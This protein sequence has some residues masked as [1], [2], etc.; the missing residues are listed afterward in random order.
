[1]EQT[2]HG[3]LLF[4][5]T[6]WALKA[7][8]AAK[9]ASIEVKLIPTPR[10]LSSDCGTALRFRW[11]DRDALIQALSEREVTFEHMAEL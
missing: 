7:E 8:K 5:S 3:V 10:H 6:N 1:M 2:Q 9:Q 4:H 11:Q